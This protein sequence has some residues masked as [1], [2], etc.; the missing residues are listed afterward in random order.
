VK[1]GKPARVSE[2]L[3]GTVCGAC[4]SPDGQ[5]IAYAWRQVVEKPDEVMEC[6]SFLLVCDA[7]G[8]NEQ[9]IATEKMTGFRAAR[10]PVLTVL[11]WR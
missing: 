3:N 11:D 4:W 10:I 9:T 1:G 8:K 5:R 6:E 2:V 7:D